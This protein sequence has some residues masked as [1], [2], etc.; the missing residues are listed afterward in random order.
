MLLAYAGG[1]TLLP[2]SAHAL[3]DTARY[4]QKET[5]TAGNIVEHE[6]KAASRMIDE[7]S[8]TFGN[9]WISRRLV[10]V[11]FEW[12]ST[13]LLYVSCIQVRAFSQEDTPR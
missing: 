1:L 4:A 8:G 7:L 6:V 2:A 10:G 9:P 11:C 3:L 12:M 13:S 5:F